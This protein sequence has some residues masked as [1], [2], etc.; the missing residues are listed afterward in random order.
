MK[1]A[2]KS[3][4]TTALGILGALALVLAATHAQLDADPVTVADWASAITGALALL[5][6]GVAARDHDVT[7]ESAGA[8]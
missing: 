5:G 6:I 2:T 7:S 8:N 1:A 3:W 4:K